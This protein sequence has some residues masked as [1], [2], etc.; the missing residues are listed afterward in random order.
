MKITL[1][2]LLQ[3]ASL[4]VV[5]SIGGAYIALIFVYPAFY[6]VPISRAQVKAAVVTEEELAT[7]KTYNDENIVFRYPPLLMEEGQG[8]EIRPFMGNS[9][10][11]N[12]F[13]DPTSPRDS[14]WYLYA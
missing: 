1:S 13:V 2:G 5:L 4:L 7:W 3:A 10:V 12:H 14:F 8:I 9:I 11:R 6:H